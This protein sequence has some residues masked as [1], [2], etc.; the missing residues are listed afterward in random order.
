MYDYDQFNGRNLTKAFL[1]FC[2]C[3]YAVSSCTTGTFNC[4]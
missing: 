2:M 1:F 4:R 3:T